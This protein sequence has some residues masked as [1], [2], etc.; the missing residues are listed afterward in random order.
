MTPTLNSQLSVG[1]GGDFMGQVVS[2]W[3]ERNRRQV[4]DQNRLGLV[5]KELWDLGVCQSI[6]LAWTKVAQNCINGELFSF[7]CYFFCSCPC[8]TKRLSLRG[9]VKKVKGFVIGSCCPACQQR[10]V[11][12]PLPLLSRSTLVTMGVNMLLHRGKG[13]VPPFVTNLLLYRT[14]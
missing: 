8:G 5:I 9:V 11:P 3:G 6:C 14:H 4:E 10:R 12:P 7:H 13:I 2:S 1:G